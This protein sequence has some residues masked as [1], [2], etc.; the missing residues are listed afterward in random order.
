MSEDI[1]ELRR[2]GI[3]R[4]LV[5]VAVLAA[6]GVALIW[7]RASRGRGEPELAHRVL[8]VGGTPT[9]LVEAIAEAGFEATQISWLEA[10]TECAN[11][12]RGLD[13]EA[14]IDHADE[15]GF[16]FVALML[17]DDM[18]IEPSLL[19][20]AAP[21]HAMAAVISVGAL[22]PE[23]ARVHFGAP[24]ATI[25]YAPGARR[26]E[27]L[28][29]AL[30]EHP[31]LLA[32]WD[33]PTRD[34]LAQQV[35][36]ADLAEAR[37]LLGRALARYRAAS[38]AW[39]SE[40]PADAMVERW[41]EIDG[42]PVHAGLVVREL[43][44][45]ARVDELRRVE[46]RRGEPK[47]RFVPALATARRAEYSTT[48]DPLADWIT[49][50][51]RSGALVREGD[52]WQRW[53]FE[54]G[55]PRLAGTLELPVAHAALSSGGSLA[56]L[57][58][59]ALHWSTADRSG[60]LDLEL[61]APGLFAWLDDERLVFTPLV[62]DELPE[63]RATWLLAVV[64]PGA[65]GGPKIAALPIDAL[66]ELGP[67]A[68]FVALHPSA[69]G[70]Y[71]IVMDS[72]EDYEQRFVLIRVEL[73]PERLRAAMVGL[74]GTTPAVLDQVDLA[75]RRTLAQLGERS[76]V[77]ELGILPSFEP[78]SLALAPDGT[79]LAW[80]APGSAN[81]I[82][83]AAIVDDRI[84]T[85]VRLGESSA[86]PRID[87]ESQTAW[88]LIERELAELGSVHTLRGVARPAG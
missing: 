19:G 3:K 41:T 34:Q 66:A 8:I 33:T 81:A 68:S 4:M 46:L 53:H 16:G 15:H 11:P 35:R 86:D 27:A 23:Q 30:Y 88:I 24:P 48:V 9:D 71:A 85:P 29:M 84:A 45:R 55:S 63:P 43:P 42:M 51:D 31:D 67:L 78:G 28:R 47:L 49:A 64:E 83:A 21:E 13:V 6:I 80:R 75:T 7:A 38:E 58:D 39:P 79:W 32:L 52:A 12:E 57:T 69:K 10:E 60:E 59:G 87:A 74:A 37:M 73:E 36:L 82:W 65:E 17:G 62:I 26:S 25:D 77:V 5:V 20:E 14:L 76:K 1:D 56:W 2:G 40:W 61:D 70:L 18:R 72:L 50:P 54:G 44:L 22:A